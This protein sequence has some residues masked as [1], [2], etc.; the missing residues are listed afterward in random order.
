MFGEAGMKKELAKER[1]LGVTGKKSV[2]LGKS[3]PGRYKCKKCELVFLSNE[4][5]IK[6]FYREKKLCARCLV[7]EAIEHKKINVPSC[8]GHKYDGA[9]PLCRNVCKLKQACIVQQADTKIVGMEWNL[10]ELPNVREMLDGKAKL[11]FRDALYVVLRVAAC[12]LHIHDIGPLLEKYY[13]PWKMS[14]RLSKTNKERWMHDIKINAK[15][16]PQIVDIGEGFFVWQGV[17]SLGTHGAI[18]YEGKVYPSIG[19]I[20]DENDV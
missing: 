15:N 18:L 6:R 20:E 7:E 14:Y 16:T 17:W 19:D 13:N 10:A 11:S 4:V 5:W 9:N 1:G 8:Y 3:G 12:P 2:S